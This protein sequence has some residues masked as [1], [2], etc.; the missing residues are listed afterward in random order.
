MSQTLRLILKKITLTPQSDGRQHILI[1]LSAREEIYVGEAIVGEDEDDL[2][3]GI[4]EATLQ[5]INKALT[6]PVTLKLVHCRQIFLA[7][8]ASIIFLVVIR[9]EAEND[10]KLLPGISLF[11]KFTVEVAAKAALKALNRTITQYF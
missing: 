7:E 1:W 11:G 8:I 3:A 9:V 6:K 4:V 5:A 2:L 10:T